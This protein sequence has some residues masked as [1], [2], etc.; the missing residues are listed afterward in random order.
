MVKHDAYTIRAADAARIEMM[1]TR[2]AQRLRRDYS[3]LV[4]I[5]KCA[6]Y[7][8]IP[9][10]TIVPTM[11]RTATVPATAIATPRPASANASI[12]VS[13]FQKTIGIN[14]GAPKVT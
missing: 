5:H 7:A 10:L 14:M 9:A 8:T 13:V 3:F 1:F 12:T 4:P 6:T 2:S 11:S